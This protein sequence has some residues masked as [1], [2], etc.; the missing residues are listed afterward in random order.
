MLS[1]N[2][3]HLS[4]MFKTLHTR[5]VTVLYVDDFDSLSTEQSIVGA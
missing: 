2:M 4:F 3:Y 5:T 1:H